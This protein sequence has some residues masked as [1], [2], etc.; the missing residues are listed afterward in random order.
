MDLS[1]VIEI[2]ICP[3]VRLISLKMRFIYR[4]TAHLSPD[5]RI[6]AVRPLFDCGMTCPVIEHYS[7]SIDA[8]IKMHNYNYFCLLY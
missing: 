4:D 1:R 8:L 2:S 3:A 6:R 7:R 5:P